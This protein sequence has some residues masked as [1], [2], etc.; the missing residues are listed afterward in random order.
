MHAANCSFTPSCQLGVATDISRAFG[1]IERLRA[2]ISQTSRLL[3]VYLIAFLLLVYICNVL[4]NAFAGREK[5]KE[6]VNKL[7]TQK[8]ELY[9]LFCCYSAKK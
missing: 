4:R 1:T 2:K 3:Y 8:L 6:V 5:K 9:W 7:D